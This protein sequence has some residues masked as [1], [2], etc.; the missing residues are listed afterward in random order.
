MHDVERL[1]SKA[2]IK[3]GTETSRRVGGI[4]AVD[5]LVW[6]PIEVL[7]APAEHFCL[8][9]HVVDE[10]LVD[11][12]LGVRQEVC[13]EDCRVPQRCHALVMKEPQ[14]RVKRV[15]SDFGSQGEVDLLGVMC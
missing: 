1:L 8:V 9:P 3:R 10:L 13:I 4:R 7:G 5:L 15:G 2:P 14:P 6:K 12:R 11:E